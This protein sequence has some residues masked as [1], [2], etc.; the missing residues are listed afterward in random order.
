METILE[1]GWKEKSVKLPNL[2]VIFLKTNQDMALQSHRILKTFVWWWCQGG[3]GKNFPP[4]LPMSEKIWRLCGA[5]ISLLALD[6]SPLNSV[7]F[8]ILI[9]S[10]QQCQWISGLYQN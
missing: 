3:G 4:T 8:L 2:N 7:N 6:I 1:H 5:A 9:C 10:F